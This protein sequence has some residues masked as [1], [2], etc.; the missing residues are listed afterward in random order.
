M[1]EQDATMIIYEQ[2]ELKSQESLA[3]Q[4]MA[5]R[6]SEANVL[7]TSFTE[8]DPNDRSTSGGGLQNEIRQI[9]TLLGL[10][11][12]DHKISA[13]KPQHMHA[14]MSLVSGDLD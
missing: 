4:K 12:R 9:K 14:R 8:G 10:I 1:V 3:G 5:Y 13:R 2:D 11:A 6:E 7:Q